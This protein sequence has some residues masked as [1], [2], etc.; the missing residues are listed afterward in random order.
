LE[1][2]PDQ[3]ERIVAGNP[4][5][6]VI[7]D[8]AYVDFGGQTALPLLEKYDNLLV[9]QTFSKS[10]A[11]A[12]ERIGFAIGNKK[13]ISYLKDV[14]FSFNS[15]TMNLPSIVMGTESVK[16]A[17]YFHATTDK[18]IATRER[19]KK[20]L[21]ELGFVFPDS[22]T[23]FVFAGHPD[24]P[25]KDLFMALRERRIFVRYFSKPRI[26]DYLRITIGTDYQMDAVLAALREIMGV[27]R[28]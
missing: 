3:I 15:Y 8:E 13:M 14:K 9:V 7:I 2:A 5:S 21:R 23:N 28:K 22:H 25:A 24:Y 26:C 16:D 12:G 6:V 27:D 19:F 1:M 17:G 4:D 11:M 18:I 20:G 10:R